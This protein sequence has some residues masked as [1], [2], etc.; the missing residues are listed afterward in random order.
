MPKKVKWLRK[1]NQP[2]R[3]FDHVTLEEDNNADA[4]IGQGACEQVEDWR[5]IGKFDDNAKAPEQPTADLEPLPDP[6]P[7]PGPPQWDDDEDES[8]KA[9]DDEDENKK[10]LD[11]TES[12]GKDMKAPMNRAIKGPVFRKGS[13][14]KK[15]RGKK[16]D[17]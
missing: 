4:W 3:A 17:D 16:T 13:S 6:E 12:V 5:P 7:Q 9:G 11:I 15:R 2:P 8:D 10:S 14:S 1:N